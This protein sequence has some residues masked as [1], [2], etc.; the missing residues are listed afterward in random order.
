MNRRNPVL[1]SSLIATT[2]LAAGSAPTQTAISHKHTFFKRGFVQSPSPQLAKEKASESRGKDNLRIA[3]W[4]MRDLSMTSRNDQERKEICYIILEN[5][6]DAVAL[7]EINDDQILSELASI[8]DR[9]GDRWKSITSKRVGNSVPA[10]EHYGVLYNED[11]LEYYE[12]WSVPKKRLLSL[13]IGRLDI[14]RSLQF[15]REPYV[16]RLGTDDGRFDM[17]LVIAHVTYGETVLPRIAEVRGLGKYYRDVLKR[18]KDVF[19]GGDFNRN[20]NDPKGIDWLMSATGLIDTTSSS[21]PTAVEGTNTYD[22]I[23]L[24]RR[25]TKEYD[26]EHGVVLFDE[27]KYGSDAAAA[28]KAVS[29]HRP[30]W[31]ELK[32]PEVDDD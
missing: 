3:F 26:D 31:I 6:F 11:V 20:S 30:V 18:E 23:M 16:V 17:A 15:N 22:H 4:N 19:V 21:P 27:L 1:V 14:P 10:S 2:L 24:N 28:K 32:V 13:G 25:Y 12:A 8:L 5:R 9:S 29:D 7:C